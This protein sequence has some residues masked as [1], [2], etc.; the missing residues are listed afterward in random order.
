MEIIAA[1]SRETLRASSDY[2]TGTVWQD[3]IANAPEPARVRA[4]RVTFEPGART[5]WHTHPLGQTL[6]VLS[7]VGLVALR[8]EAPRII[9][10]GDTVWIPPGEEHWHGAT[11]T[12]GM[13]HLAIQEAVDGAT[14]NWLDHVSD[15]DYSIPPA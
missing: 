14:A 1:G 6:H 9:R 5:A 13:V 3:T 12:T 7:G 15:E 11:A 4:L 10:P 2:F 8:N